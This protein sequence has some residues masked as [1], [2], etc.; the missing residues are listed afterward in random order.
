MVDSA[1]AAKVNLRIRMSI[2]LILKGPGNCYDLQDWIDRSD[3]CIQRV[4]NR[5]QTRPRLRRLKPELPIFAT[6]SAGDFG[7][8]K[9]ILTNSA[10]NFSACRF[11][12]IAPCR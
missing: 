7:K 4:R 11:L 1:A 5:A 6:P 9:L 12:L 10:R 3:R 8:L 2:G